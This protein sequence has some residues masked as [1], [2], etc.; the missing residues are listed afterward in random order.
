MLAYGRK[1]RGPKIHPHNECRV[2]SEIAIQKNTARKYNQRDLLTEALA[3]FESGTIMGSDHDEETCVICYQE[4]YG[5]MPENP[6]DF[7]YGK[8]RFETQ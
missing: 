4:F 8:R 2:C 6:E 1:K 5:R 3:D 7:K